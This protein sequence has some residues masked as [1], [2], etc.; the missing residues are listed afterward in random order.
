MNKLYLCHTVWAHVISIIILRVY[1]SSACDMQ[2]VTSLPVCPSRY[3]LDVLIPT[4]R[5]R[6][7][8]SPSVVTLK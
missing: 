7:L 1:R 6:A 2:F 8:F 3:D 4:M 5:K